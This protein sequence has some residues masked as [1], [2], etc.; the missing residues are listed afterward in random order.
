M[1]VWTDTEL[2]LIALNKELARSGDPARVRYFVIQPDPGWD[3]ELVTAIWALPPLERRREAWSERQSMKY[4]QMLKKWLLKVDRVAG[5]VSTSCVFRT[6]QTAASAYRN[7]RPVPETPEALPYDMA[8]D[9]A[10]FTHRRD[11]HMS[12]WDETERSLA[13]LNVEMARNR[14]PGRIRYYVI[15]P[16]PDWDGGWL[17][18]VWELPPPAPGQET[19]PEHVGMNYE[20]ILEDR[21]IR[22]D[23]VAGV[24]STSCLFR[25]ANDVA[26]AF[27]DA[28]PV[29]EVAD[30]VAKS[31]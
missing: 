23:R 22:E 14:D 13:K 28:L 27:S 21:V 30:S 19:W 15:R 31:R 5:V 12:I 29:P 10:V 24:V 17:T 20:Q 7:A 26:R 11:K 2:S 18:A 3:G 25:T 16:D 1:D 9:V 4:E 6:A 8:A